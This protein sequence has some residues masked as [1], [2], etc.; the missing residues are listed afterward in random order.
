MIETN[1][2]VIELE[3]IKDKEEIVFQLKGIVCGGRKT[4]K[5]TQSTVITL[6]CTRHAYLASSH[7]TC[8]LFQAITEQLF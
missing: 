6:N 3:R 1:D 8:Y 5:E 7:L 4:H 2:L